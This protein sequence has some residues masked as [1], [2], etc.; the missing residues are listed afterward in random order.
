MNIFEYFDASG[1]VMYIDHKRERTFWK[2][3]D[4]AE[5]VPWDGKYK[6][7]ISKDFYKEAAAPRHFFKSEHNLFYLIENHQ[8]HLPHPAEVETDQINIPRLE[9]E[10]LPE[11]SDLREIKP[12]FTSDSYKK[13]IVKDICLGWKR[14]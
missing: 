5:I 8:P 9:M 4:G 11:W 7:W 2:R 12:S 1:Q 10:I 3:D 13:N 6:G 14:L